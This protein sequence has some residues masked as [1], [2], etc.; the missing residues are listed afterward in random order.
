[1]RK[2]NKDTIISL[3]EKNCKEKDKLREQN[4]ALT[5]EIAKLQ[6]RIDELQR[7]ININKNPF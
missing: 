5:D 1:M 7:E 6:Y 4:K 3:V 2:L